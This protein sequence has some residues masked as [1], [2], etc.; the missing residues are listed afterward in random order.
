[1]KKYI[2]ILLFSLLQIALIQAQSFTY[3]GKNLYGLQEYVKDSLQRSTNLLFNDIDNDGDQDLILCGTDSIKY[4]QSGTITSFSQITYFISVQENTGTKWI[5]KF[6][7]RKPFMDSFPFRKGYFIPAAGDLNDDQKLDFIISSGLDSNYNMSTLYYQRKEIS[8]KQQFNIISGETMGLD[9]FVSGSLFTPS[10]ADMDKDGDLDIFMSGYFMVIN[11]AGD[12]IQ[13][14]AFL[15]A[16]NTGTKSN[17]VFLSWYHNTNGLEKNIG[18]NQLIT[19]GDVDNDNDNDIISLSNANNVSKLLYLENASRPDGKADF[20]LSKPLT[21]IPTTKSGERYYPPT[22]VDIDADGDLD[23]FMLQD[24]TKAATGIGYYENNFCTAKTTQLPRTFCDGDSIVIGNQIFKQTGQYVVKLK[25]I[26]GCDSIVQASLTFVT[27]NNK[28]SQNKLTL[29]A[30]LSGV[31]YQWFDCN[32]GLNIAGATSQS[33][34]PTMNGKYGVKLTNANGCKNTS[35]CVDFVITSNEESFI[36]SK[37]ILS[38]NPS[39]DYLTISNQTEFEL[40]SVKIINMDG[41]ILKTIPNHQM[42]KINIAT[43]NPGNY[44]MEIHCNGNKIYK[45]FEI[46]R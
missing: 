27:L 28:V 22:L 23:L 19:I 37:I 40:T 24:L 6:A 21:G 4:N 5:P 25:S 41:K 35:T 16:K 20:K 42:E 30:E 29:T 10:L 43:L 7:A 12:K 13:T 14:P 26:N 31:Q 3:K 36:S 15:Y 17:P 34:T 1:M 2:T 8:G 18:G 32:T 45:K 39:S 9:P 38:P 46:V 11:A 44:V 33:Y